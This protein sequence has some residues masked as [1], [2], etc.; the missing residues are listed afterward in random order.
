[1]TK[2]KRIKASLGFART[3]HAALVARLNAVHDGMSGNPAYPSPPV[4]LATFKT[5]IDSF[6]ASIAEALDGGKK[7][8][9][10]KNQQREAVIKM[11][12]QLG[13]YVQANCRDDLATFTSSGFQALSNSR[14]P[15]QPLPQP[16]ISKV[17]QGTTGQ[18]L[19]TVKALR[20]ALS[21]EL[22]YAALGEGGMPGAWTT[23][24]LTRAKAASISSLT[25]GTTYTFQTRALGRLGFTDWSDSVNRMCI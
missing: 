24:V 13:H 8:I 14:T 21:Y 17:D 23:A 9:T 19:V 7:A 11:A 15:S 25:P 20:K 6:A 22:R 4:D 10:A 18:L 2:L 1:M 16:T 5:A 12:E 3:P